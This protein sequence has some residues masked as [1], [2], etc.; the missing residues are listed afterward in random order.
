VF[1]QTLS[2][3]DRRRLADLGITLDEQPL[4]SMI[5]VMWLQHQEIAAV[6]ERIQRL[7]TRLMS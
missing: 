2:D 5:R 3:E 7:E 4:P 1:A 6:Y